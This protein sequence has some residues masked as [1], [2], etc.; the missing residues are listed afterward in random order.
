MDQPAAWSD[1]ILNRDGVWLNGRRAGEYHL[2][3]TA[4]A[5]VVRTVRLRDQGRKTGG[6][7]RRIGRHFVA[8]YIAPD[9][10]VPTLQIGLARYPLDGQTLAVHRRTRLGLV[11]T[12]S[13]WRLGSTKTTVRHL[14][15]S[16]PVLRR[17]DPGYDELD[18]AT[19]DFLADVADMV[20][21]EHRQE[22]LV[23]IKDPSAGPWA[24]IGLEA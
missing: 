11:S 14:E 6:V 21:S 8:V 19:D 18:I 9:T 17:I 13:V 2:F 10:R 4:S 22:W 16:S 20:A 15:M 3:D 5:R 7:G 12:L 23:K 1:V 24:E